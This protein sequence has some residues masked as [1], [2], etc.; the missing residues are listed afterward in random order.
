MIKVLKCLPH[1]LGDYERSCA[2]DA[3]LR[4]RRSLLALFDRLDGAEMGVV[5]HNKRQTTQDEY[6]HCRH[7]RNDAPQRLDFTAARVL[8]SNYPLYLGGMLWR[9]HTPRVADFGQRWLMEIFLGTR[10]DQIS[11]PW[12]LAQAQVPV[13]VFPRRESSKLVM[14]HRHR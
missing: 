9:W 2:M 7:V 11:L 6:R 8:G 12:A 3:N 13:R 4:P 1:L 14:I 5:A 10:R